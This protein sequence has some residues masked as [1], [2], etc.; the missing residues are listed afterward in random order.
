MPSE[1]R[2]LVEDGLAFPVVH[3]SGVLDP[4]SAVALREALVTVLATQPQAVVVDVSALAV[5]DPAAAQVL[6]AVLETV[7]AEIADWPATQLALCAPDDRIGPATGLPTWPTTPAAIA[8][9]G[10]PTPE[11]YRHLDLDPEPGAARSARRLLTDACADWALD[12]LAGSSCIVLTEMVNNV[13]AHAHT[14]MTVLL[15]R[16]DE[17]LSLAV[18]DGSPTIPHFSGPVA[19]TAYGGRGLL[20][21]DSVADR[22]GCLAADGGKVV[23]ALMDGVSEEPE[24]ARAAVTGRDPSRSRTA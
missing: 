23:W 3:F 21:I 7:A 24:D 5:P 4:G 15:S 16:R 2:H 12:D 19:P 9:L 20:L 11:A 18:R 13:V 6:E 8:A 14:P 10:R 17:R 22:W 1:V